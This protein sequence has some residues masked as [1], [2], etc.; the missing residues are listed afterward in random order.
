[1]RDKGFVISTE[2]GYAEVEVTCLDACKDCA[3][4]NLCGGATQNKG[5]LSV[6]NTLSAKP[7]DEVM[8]EIPD[9]HYSRALS[10]LFGLLLLSLLTGLGAGY[11]A[12]FLLAVSSPLSSLVG[13]V[14]GL[15]FGGCGIYYVF[16]RKNKYRLYPVITD[17]IKKGDC[18]GQA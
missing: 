9:L 14:L 6:K 15:L 2:N 8:I 12:S 3:A 17:I 11:L 1:M 16:Q 4:H 5:R 10:Q 13:L 7:G 18:H